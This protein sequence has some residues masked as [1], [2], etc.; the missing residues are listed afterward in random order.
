MKLIRGLEHLSYEDRLRDLG[1]FRPEKRGP[2]GDL[3]A[4]FPFLKGPN[5]RDRE[6]LFTQAES[7]R[8]RQ[9]GFKLKK[10]R[11]RSDIR[12]KFFTV[13]VVMHWNRLPREAVDAAFLAMFK[14]RLDGALSNLIK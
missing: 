3:R 13:R 8:T 6:G 12:K 9:N 5:K 10:G 2:W 4:A 7:D 11:L 1:W 14:A